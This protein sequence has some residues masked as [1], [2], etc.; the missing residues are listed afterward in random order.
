MRCGF[1][2]AWFDAVRVQGDTVRLPCG[3]V[4]FNGLVAMCAV[5]FDGGPCRHGRWR[6]MPATHVHTLHAR[7]QHATQTDG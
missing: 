5:V 1:N 3:A 6:T 2:T 4:K 7:R